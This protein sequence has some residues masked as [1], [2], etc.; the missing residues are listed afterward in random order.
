MNTDLLLCE[1]CLYP[2]PINAWN[3]GRPGMRDVHKKLSNL[4]LKGKEGHIFI[5][6]LLFL[7][8]MGKGASIL[9]KKDERRIPLKAEKLKA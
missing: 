4:T 2:R 5:C 1:D 3:E 9:E 7:N 8:R 6:H